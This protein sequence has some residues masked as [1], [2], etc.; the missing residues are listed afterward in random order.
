MR[1][2]GSLERLISIVFRKDS[3]LITLRP[4]QTTTYTADRS[5]DLPPGDSDHTLVS[6][7]GT[8]VLTNKTLDGDDNTIQDLALTSIKTVLADANKI[9]RRDSTGVI[10]SSAVGTLSDSGTLA[11]LTQLHVDNLELNNNTISSTDTNGSIILD[12]DGTGV[13]DV[14]STLTVNGAL[15]SSTSL[16][17]EDPG[18][19]TNTVTIQAPTLS[20]N[21]TLTL[22]VDDGNAGQ[23]LATDGSGNLSWVADQTGA[24][25]AADWIA[26]DGATK[27]I[28]HNLGTRDIQIEIYDTVSGSTILV[29]SMTR[30]DTN[31][32]DLSA[33][34]APATAWR[35]LLATI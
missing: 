18:A 24:S 11:G 30:T 29:D 4:S 19:G 2:Y 6:A 26:A 28:V 15:Q 31:T 17:L 9:L 1:F 27:T 32:L 34:E 33:S 14:Q 22:P 16:V 8:Q 3:Q 23:L 20:G 5:V 10:V 35:V 13:V 7:S 21:Y 12:P 25:F